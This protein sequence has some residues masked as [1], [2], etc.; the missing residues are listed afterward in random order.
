MPRD[1][2]QAAIRHFLDAQML[3]EAGRYDDAGHLIGFAAECALK[4]AASGF[5]TPPNAE[6]E[7]HLPGPLK[8]ADSKHPGS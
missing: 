3:A 7:G 2:G 5:T 6:I 8:K 1:Y 4:K